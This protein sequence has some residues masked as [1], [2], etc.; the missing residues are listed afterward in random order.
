MIAAK[1]TDVR[2]ERG[3]TMVEFALIMPV[4]CM[5]LFAIIQ[6]GILFN[7]YLS[8]DRRDSG[9]STQSRRQPDGHQSGRSHRGRRPHRRGRP[10]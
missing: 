8:S 2:S 9:R 7:D 1:R 4:L 3:Q 5:V 6:F 10:E